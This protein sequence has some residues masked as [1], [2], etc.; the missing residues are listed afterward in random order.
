ME[1]K[2]FTLLEMLIVTFVISIGLIAIM[3]LILQ[4]VADSQ[5]AF[6]RLVAAYLAQE[7][8]EIVGNIRDSN[9]LAQRQNPGITWNQNLNVGDWEASYDKSSL[10]PYADRYLKFGGGF[11]NYTSGVNTKFKRK[12]TIATSTSQIIDVSVQVTWQERGKS[13]Q[14]TT[15]RQLYNWR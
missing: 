7:G 4:A 8:L 1:K 15:Q 12:I 11:Y 3:T 10:D 6:S 9:W 2:G 13:H 14:F 5:I